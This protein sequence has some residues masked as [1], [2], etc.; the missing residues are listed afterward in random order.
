[1][2]R[3][4]SGSPRTAVLSAS[5]LALTAGCA[6]LPHAANVE[7][8]ARGR[9]Y[10]AQYRDI[11]TSGEVAPVGSSHMLNLAQCK[12]YSEGSKA[13]G[14]LPSALASETLSP[15]DL[16]SLRLHGDDTFT[17]DYVVS[18]DGTLKLPYLPSIPARG[19]STDAVRRDIVAALEKGGFYDAETP[20]RVS[21]LVKDFAPASVAV[22]GAVFEPHVAEI[23]G[24]SSDQRD[25]LRE[26]ALGAST[27]G[28]DLSV[29]LRAAGGVRPDADLSDVTVIRGGH[30][31]RL[32]LRGAITGRGFDDAMLATGDKVI[33]PSRGCFQE[34]LMQPSPISPPGIRLFLSNLTA[35]ATG[36][37]PSAIGREVR[38]V[39][40]GTRFLQAVVNANCVGGA[41][42]TSADRSAALFTR[43]PITKVSAVIER[44]VEVMRSRA[45]RDEFDP[46]LL[47]GDAIACYDSGATNLFEIGRLIG[48]FR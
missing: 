12:P 34:D 4:R 37:A 31:Y 42:A 2:I 23:G 48:V 5:L 1:M 28:R 13:P 24:V 41:R 27:R 8:V 33:V 16:L 18:R 47:P 19:R 11:P 17:G 15:D 6:P 20:P 35:P 30:R 36:N 7:P 32:D 14:R 44:K 39:P 26:N 38:E 45:D 25:T 22:S 43:N 40:Y 10:E 3:R 29:A 21:L 9:A 46:Y